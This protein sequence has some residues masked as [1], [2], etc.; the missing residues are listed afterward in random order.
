MHILIPQSIVQCA[1]DWSVNSEPCLGCNN[2]MAA[3]IQQ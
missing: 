3:Q 2:N 1:M